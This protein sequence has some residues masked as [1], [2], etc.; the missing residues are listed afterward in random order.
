M[1]GRDCRRITLIHGGGSAKG[2]LMGVY[3]KEKKNSLRLEKLV[4]T[5]IGDN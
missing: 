1:L 2:L 3:K 5:Q 4:Q